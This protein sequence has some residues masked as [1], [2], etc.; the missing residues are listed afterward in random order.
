MNPDASQSGGRAAFPEDDEVFERLC[1]LDAFAQFEATMD[2]ALEQL[3]ARWK[4]RA[5]PNAGLRIRATL[6]KK[7]KKA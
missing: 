6:P 4:H 1:D 5:A 7:H 2:L 3:V